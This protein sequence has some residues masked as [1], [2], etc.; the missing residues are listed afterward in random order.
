MTRVSG[1]VVTVPSLLSE[2]RLL[3]FHSDLFC[4]YDIDS[5]MSNRTLQQ[6]SF[7]S[8]LRSSESVIVFTEQNPWIN[9]FGKTKVCSALLV[10]SCMDCGGGV[11]EAVQYWLFIE[12]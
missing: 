8:M 7:R 3:V 11:R 12:L 9:V 1:M 10:K 5:W 2:E 6:Q 4:T